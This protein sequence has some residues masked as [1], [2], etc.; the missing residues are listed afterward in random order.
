M[1]NREKAK[2][3]RKRSPKASTKQRIACFFPEALSDLNPNWKAGN[4]RWNQI[5]LDQK[6]D[7]NK[8]E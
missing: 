4:K 7:E 6:L 1:E 2:S 5:W 8:I 3:K